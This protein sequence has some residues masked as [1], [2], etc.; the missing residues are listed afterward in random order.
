MYY[1]QFLLSNLGRKKVRTILTLLSI[2]IAF[3]LFGL[4]RSLAAAFDQGAEIAGEDRLVSIN[5]VSLIQPIP[6]SYLAKIQSLEGVDRATSANWFGGYYQDPKN[7]FPQFPIVAEDY[8]EI[9]KEMIALPDEQMQ[10]WKKNRIGVVIGKALVERFKW[11]IGDRIPL[12]GMFPKED[13]N[14]TWEFVIEGIYEAKN[15]SADTSAMLM[16]YDYFDEARQYGKGTLGWLIIRVK[17]PKQSAQVAAA[18]DAMFA[19]SPAE[20]KT[21]SE[22]EFAKSFAKQFGDIGLI[23]TL[24]LGAVFF[25]MLLVAGNTMAQSFRE[26]IPELAI[27][28]TLGF[29]DVAVM[30]LVLAEAIVISLIGGLAGL[31]LAKFFIS[32][33]AESMAATLPGLNLSNSM[34]LFGIALMFAFG[35]LTG[36]IPALQG[37]R[38]NIVAALRRR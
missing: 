20:T 4:L 38:L 11:K 28:K 22:K 30:L 2:M 27:L 13:G 16:H 15:K 32:G 1:L 23:T 34:M 6:E 18:I 35:L 5:K 9:Y 36:I 21:S 29:S 33:A 7:Q 25:T 12:K 14:T 17:D 31:L 10:A 3:L 37:L 19:N 26:R 8:F 24:I